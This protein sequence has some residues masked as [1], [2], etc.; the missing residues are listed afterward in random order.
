[1]AEGFLRDFAGDIFDVFSAGVSPAS[2]NPYA[3]RVM[4]ETGIDISHQKSKSTGDFKDIHFDYVIT[5]R[6]NARQSCPLFPGEY[7][8]IH[9]DIKDPAGA[10]GSAEEIMDIFRSSRDRVKK[11]IEKFIVS[12]RQ[13]Q[14]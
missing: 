8:K 2:V 5:V 10:K 3:V 12:A 13:D 7:R 4:S 9:W 6:D 14:I 11:E 1:M